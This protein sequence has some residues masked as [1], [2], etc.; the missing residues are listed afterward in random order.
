MSKLPSHYRSLVAEN[1]SGNID[2][3]ESLRC[4]LK[5]QPLSPLC[6]DTVRVQVHYSGI[7]FKDALAITGKGKILRSLPLTPGIDASG[8]VVES[9]SPAFRS[10]ESVLVTGC[11]LGESVNGGLGEFI[12]VPAGWVIPLPK[13]LSLKSCIILGTAG[14]T[15]ALAL[16]QLEWNGLK[17]S[18]IPVLIT[19]ATGG[20]GSL[21]TLMLKERGYKVEA[22]TRKDTERAYLKSL[23]ADV[24]TDISQLSL[25]TRPL[26]SGKW[27]AAIDN[28]GG[29]ILSYILPRIKPHGSV[30]SIGLAKSSALSTTVF[31]FILRGVNILGISSATCP[32]DLREKIWKSINTMNGDWEKALTKELD[33]EEVI[34]F[35]QE[36]ISGKTKG[37]A[38]VEIGT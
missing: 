23:G 11:G 35:A 7:N 13:N 21:A 26:E 28:V 20:V 32:R 6:A 16:H 22:W 34:P 37:R 3:L 12:T 33:L 15:A 25:N 1:P 36:M 30:A 2:N 4:S 19:G 27:S 10:G 24:I 9:T 14:F 8:I 31:P 5:E 29:D 38:L 18:D 17:P